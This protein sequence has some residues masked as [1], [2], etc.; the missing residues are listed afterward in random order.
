MNITIAEFLLEGM[1]VSVVNEDL[2][3]TK[4]CL[5]VYVPKD[6]IDSVKENGISASRDK[7]LSAL[8]WRI[9]EEFA[10]EDEVPLK[11]SISKLRKT[12]GVVSIVSDFP[13]TKEQKVL[14]DDDISKLNDMIDKSRLLFKK[15]L[16]SVP[17]AT[18]TIST[19]FIQP[20]AFKD[21]VEESFNYLLEG[22]DFT[23]SIK[24]ITT[25]VKKTFEKTGKIPDSVS[26]YVKSNY[27]KAVSI[28][29][30]KEGTED[31]LKSLKVMTSRTFPEFSNN[32][33]ILNAISVAA[34]LRSMVKN[35]DVKTSIITIKNESYTDERS[36]TT[37]EREKAMTVIAYLVVSVAALAVLINLSGSVI[38]GA[39]LWAFFIIILF[40]IINALYQIE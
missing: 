29:K 3:I 31:T 21:L 7:P 27:D 28:L 14:S 22:V 38:G 25:T 32:R 11:I 30:G 19:G 17:K 39:I 33:H 10:N 37:T 15:G 23:N 6:E 12:D 20:F 2:L 40:S 18:I 24:Y 36:T 4:P 1:D 8:F 26:K 13:T 34:Y 5:Y 16:D 35:E 9:P